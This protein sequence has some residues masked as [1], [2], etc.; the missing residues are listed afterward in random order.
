MEEQWRA[1]VG[2]AGYEVSDHG[3]VR[4]WVYSLRHANES[5]PRPTRHR[6]GEDGYARVPLI[7]NKKKYSRYAHRLVLEAF[8]G[9]CPRG[10]EC[11]HDNG[12]RSDNRFENLFWGTKEQNAED[13]RRHGSMPIGERNGKAK[14]TEAQALTV[15][16]SSEPHAQVAARFNIH[17]SLVSHIKTGRAWAHLQ[18]V[19]RAS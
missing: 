8:R 13:K 17:K 1:V 14:L 11:R 6:I 2:F 9:P 15:L 12:I 10:Q 19:R 7:R 5:L 18:G 3:N 16:H 4:S